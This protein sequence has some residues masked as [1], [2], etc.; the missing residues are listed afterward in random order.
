MYADKQVNGR[1]HTLCP[2]RNSKHMHV[3]YHPPEQCGSPWTIGCIDSIVQVLATSMHASLCPDPTE[4][5][6]IDCHSHAN[7]HGKRRSSALTCQL[8]NAYN[9]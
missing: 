3:R 2:G 4:L 6:Y 5:C 7:T 8:A 1:R 9:R